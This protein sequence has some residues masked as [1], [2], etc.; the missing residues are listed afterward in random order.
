[1]VTIYHSLSLYQPTCCCPIINDNASF[2][3]EL[4][5]LI[6]CHVELMKLFPLQTSEA[7]VNRNQ[8]SIIVPSGSS[9]EEGSTAFQN[10]L[11]EIHEETS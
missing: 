2:H 8:S 11:Q 1:M 9:D 7:S 10:V 3:L 5:D 4:S 6:H